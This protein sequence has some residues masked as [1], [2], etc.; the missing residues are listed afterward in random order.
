MLYERRLRELLHQGWD[1]VHCWEEPYI[2]CG[3]QVAMWTPDG[4][5]MVFWTAQNISKQYP[6][7]FSWIENYTVNRCAGWLA[8]GT[9][10]VDTML[11]RGY[12][13]KPYS[14]IPLGVDAEQF[15][16]DLSAR[17]QVLHE[18]GW[19]D[20]VHTP[21]IGFLGRFVPE[22]GLGLLMNA[23]DNVS[24]QWRML[25]VGDGPLK[26]DMCRWAERY[27]GRVR[28]QT[29]VK[30]DQVA[31]YLNAMDLLCA[32]SQTTS[33]WREQFGRMIAEAFACGVPVIASDSGE[34][35]WVVGDAGIIVSEADTAKWTRTIDEMLAAPERRRELAARGLE[36]AHALYSWKVLARKYLEFFDRIL[37]GNN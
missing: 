35:A 19:S 22:K 1:L 24:S 9:S 27:P 5:P 2:L 31:A 6:V 21:V 7:P 36:R 29:G 30:H 23:L 17:R 25:F 18:L 20:A 13:K 10:V 32:P 4:T 12:G 16:P 37:D 28:I 8:C 15:H 14:V 11:K 33:H 26:K 3:G 34:I